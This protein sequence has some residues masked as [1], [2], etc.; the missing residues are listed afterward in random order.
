[1]LSRNI[2]ETKQLAAGLKPQ[3]GQVIALQG[4]L[5][6]GKTT[7]T[8]GLAE[9]LGVT[10]YV[11]SP[12]FTLVNEYLTGTIPIYHIDLYRLE[13]FRDAFD[14][15]ILEYLPSANGLT[16]VEWADKIPE[17]LP[18]RY[19]SVKLQIIDEEHREIIIK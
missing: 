2:Y 9:S 13:S 7:F 16:I 5:G 1:M 8:Q 18:D 4:D 12:T 17:L 14:A 11:T 6:A 10:D 3:A 19:T 15:G